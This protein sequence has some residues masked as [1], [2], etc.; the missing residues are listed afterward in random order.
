[1]VSVI[2][3][4]ELNHNMNIYIQRC[5]RIALVM[6]VIIMPVNAKKRFQP[7]KIIKGA[8]KCTLGIP[9]SYI[10]FNFFEQNRRQ[11]PGAMRT[12]Q[13]TAICITGIPGAYF[14]YSGIKDIKKGIGL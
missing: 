10:S 1:M 5:I 11:D 6:S 12:M 13:R 7:L 4:R 9:L 14:M 8:I 2:F 3:R